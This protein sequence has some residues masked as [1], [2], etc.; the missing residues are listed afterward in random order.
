MPGAPKAVVL[1]VG[2]ISLPSPSAG[3]KKSHEVRCCAPARPDKD[4]VLRAPSNQRV[5]CGLGRAECGE[6]GARL[7][8]ILSSVTGTWPD[9]VTGSG[10]FACGDAD[11]AVCR[12]Q[13]LIAR[14]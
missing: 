3:A 8:R 9:Q 5:E 4:S 14:Q 13:F 2:F 10:K 6:R 1:S 7:I 12:G 11:R